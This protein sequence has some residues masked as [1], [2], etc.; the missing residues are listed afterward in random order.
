VII[1]ARFNGP[2]GTGNGGYSAGLL[3]SYLSGDGD[4][5]GGDGIGGDGIEVTLRTPPPLDTELAVTAIPRHGLRAY[6]GE[7]LVAEAVLSPVS[8]DDAVP[9]VTFDDAV[10]VSP[11]YPGF[12]DHP[13]P[14]C[15]V[16]GPK[17]PAGDGLGLFPGVLP[18]GRTAAPFVVG[19][20]MS[21]V[22][23]WAALDCPGGWSVPMQARPYVL[24]RI[25]ARIEAVPAPGERCVVMGRMVRTEGRRA[26]VLSTVYGPGGDLLATARAIWVAAKGPS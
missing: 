3:A 14:T 16:C 1:S 6:D 11:T 9:A 7:L 22:L 20:D 25:A 8:L 12:Q 19:E 26:H 17:R 21:P 13:F 23:V 2:P 5:I 15:F 4:G 24:G 10:D 18:D